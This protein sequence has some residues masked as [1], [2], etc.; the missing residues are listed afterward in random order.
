ME[1]GG[2]KRLLPKFVFSAGSQKPVALPGALFPAAACVH[3][4]ASKA[5]SQRL[6][7]TEKG[8]GVSRSSQRS[9]VFATSPFFARLTDSNQRASFPFALYK[10][11]WL[12][13]RTGRSYRLFSNPFFQFFFL[14]FLSVRPCLEQIPLFNILTTD[15]P[16]LCSEIASSFLLIH[17]IQPSPTLFGIV[18]IGV[19]AQHLHLALFCRYIATGFVYFLLFLPRPASDSSALNH[20]PIAHHRLVQ[21]L[22]FLFF[23]AVVKEKPEA[24]RKQQSISF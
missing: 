19:V 3:S 8:V 16:F 10:Y 22:H 14:L 1:V 9:P 5:G 24:H 7:G 15:A 20:H 4:M 6:A 2:N 18:V 12:W 21:I 17:N 23:F 13:R 11:R